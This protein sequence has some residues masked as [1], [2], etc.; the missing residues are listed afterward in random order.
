MSDQIARDV[1]NDTELMFYEKV[2][3]LADKHRKTWVGKSRWY[4]FFGLLEEVWELFWAI[5]GTHEH[6]PSYELMQIAAICLNM[7][8]HGDVL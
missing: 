7:E 4:W 3:V 2:Y 1:Y 6:R 8:D 5:V